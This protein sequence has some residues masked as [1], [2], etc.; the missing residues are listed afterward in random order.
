MVSK[1]KKIRKVKSK[2][3]AV[4]KNEI[5]VDKDIQYNCQDLD[6]EQNMD[7]QPV[8]LNSQNV[9]ITLDK[10]KSAKITGKTV[11]ACTKNAAQGVSVY[12]FF[13]HMCKKPVYE[14]NSDKNGHYTFEDL[15]PGYYTLFARL[16]D[17]RYESY[18]VKVLQGQ[19]VE[20][21]IMLQ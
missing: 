12:L 16:Q 18:F 14:T 9:N 13:G 5:K 4:P 1:K 8:Q 2:I 3:P 15:P 20:H 11:M 6:Q 17:Y 21:T 19:H 10:E 7:V